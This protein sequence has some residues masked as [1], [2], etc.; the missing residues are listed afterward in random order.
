VLQLG[1]AIDGGKDSLSMATKVGETLAVSPGELVVM[2]YAPVPDITNVVTPDLKVRSGYVN[3][4]GVIDLGFGNNR[5]GGSS[6][7][8][9]LGQIGNEAPDIED[10]D[11]LRR[12][13]EAVQ[14]LIAEGVIVS[15]HDRSD[16]GLITALA[17]MC[18]A[19]NCGARVHLPVGADIFAELFTEEAGMLFEYSFVDGWLADRILEKHGVRRR[20]VSIVARADWDSLEV[21]CNNNFIFNGQIKEL[22]ALWEATSTALEL[23]Q[24]SLETVEAERRS[25]ADGGVPAYKLS[26]E[27][28]AP[29]LVRG[30]TPKVAILRE[31]GTNGDREM[32]AAFYTAGFEPCD[33]AMSDLLDG[34]VATLDDF[35]G[36]VFP[37]R[38]S[39]AD[40]FGSAAGWAGRYLII[41]A[42]KNC[43]VA[44]TGG[45][46]RFLLAS[47]T[48]FS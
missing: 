30:Y 48:A 46:R 25:H 5:L 29:R 15:Y 39:Y 28:K 44:F 40:V 14:E 13:F 43:S 3:A 24:T 19:G 38:F 8:Q 41:R 35:R 11:L 23:Q 31:E 26:F 21:R 12:A 6:L 16:G 10:V 18:M 34:R 45:R 1:I 9:A 7:A 2:G 32:A 22:R 27:P 17:E 42:S 37:G 20:R 47:A 36:L 4:V 33:V